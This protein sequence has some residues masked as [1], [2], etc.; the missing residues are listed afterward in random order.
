VDHIREQVKERRRNKTKYL[1]NVIDA[2]FSGHVGLSLRH[3]KCFDTPMKL[4]AHKELMDMLYKCLSELPSRLA[5]VFIMKEI[6]GLSTKEI[7]EHLN[8]TSTNCWVILHR[9]RQR[10]RACLETYLLV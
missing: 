6:D 2:N 3:G 1:D 9:A 5:E 4:F 10:L 7:C 8:I